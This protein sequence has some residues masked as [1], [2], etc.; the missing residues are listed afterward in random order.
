MRFMHSRPESIYIAA[1]EWLDSF[2]DEE[3]EYEDDFD[4]DESIESSLGA[5]YFYDS[6]STDGSSTSRAHAGMQTHHFP[7]LTSNQTRNHLNHQYSA[8]RDRSRSPW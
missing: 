7:Y 2:S 5:G 3:T 1:Q 4:D 6:I 8:R